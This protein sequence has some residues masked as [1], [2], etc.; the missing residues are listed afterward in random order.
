MLTNRS[1]KFMGNTVLAALVLPV[2]LLIALMLLSPKSVSKFG[3]ATL[4]SYVAA[5]KQEMDRA[6]N[7]LAKGQIATL[8]S[9]LDDWKA[10]K[11]GDRVYKFKRKLFRELC[12]HLYKERRYGELLDFSAVWSALDERDITALAFK[13]E[14]MRHSGDRGAEGEDGLRKLWRQFPNNAFLRM[15]YS[16]FAAK[17]GDE[18]RLVEES[19]KSISKGWQLFW[20]SGDG[21][22]ADNSQWLELS[23]VEEDIWSIEIEVS[24]QVDLWRIDLPSYSE[25]RISDITVLN[26]GEKCTLPIEKLKLNQMQLIKGGSEILAKEEEDPFFYF[27]SDTC[28]IDK[29]E[30]LSKISIVFRVVPDNSLY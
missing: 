22:K 30:K 20:D 26:G 15:F 2:I 10:I 9:L 1:L 18:S 5:H 19:K 25:L 16:P 14:A 12:G 28:I 3:N 29:A 17:Y 11:K 24:E 6:L 7:H 23:L 4:I 8:I 21:F 27:R 13:F